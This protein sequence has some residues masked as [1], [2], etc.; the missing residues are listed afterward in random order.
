MNVERDCASAGGVKNRWTST[1]YDDAPLTEH[2]HYDVSRDGQRLLM[3]KH[4]EPDGPG[5]VRVVL[6]W[7]QT[8]P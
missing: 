5:E 2:Q 7:P 6:G 1:A 8:L 3:V 4:G